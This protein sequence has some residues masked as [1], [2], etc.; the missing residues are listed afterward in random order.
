MRVKLWIGIKYRVVLCG[1]MTSFYLYTW[2]RD[3]IGVGILCQFIYAEP[4]SVW[5]MSLFIITITPHQPCNMIMVR[6]NANELPWRVLCFIQGC[7]AHR[8][9]QLLL[10]ISRR[11]GKKI[12]R[13]L[14]SVCI[15]LNGEF[16][17]LCRKRPST[18][19]IT[20]QTTG[21]CLL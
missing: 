17:R 11:S 13:Y 6:P 9:D 21:V 20:K 10:Q 1:V 18:V 19:H 12:T 16:S 4:V 14:H 15:A 8:S 5:P 7:R 3:K 2:P